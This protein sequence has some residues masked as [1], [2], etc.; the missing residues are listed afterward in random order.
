MQAHMQDLSYKGLSKKYAAAQAQSLTM[1]QFYLSI[2]LFLS[3]ISF[4][5]ELYYSMGV[6]R[7][8]TNLLHAYTKWGWH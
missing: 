8:A 6:V 4:S 1:T 2:Y 7:L 5:A 3:W